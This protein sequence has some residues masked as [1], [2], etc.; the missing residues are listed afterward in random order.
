VQT[1]FV[2]DGAAITKLRC[3]SGVE[4]GEANSR[5]VLLLLI[6]VVLVLVLLMD[7]GLMLLGL[8]FRRGSRLGG[9]TLDVWTSLFQSEIIRFTADQPPTKHSEKNTN[10]ETP[11]LNQTHLLSIPSCQQQ[12]H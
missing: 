2:L 11:C 6:V 8:L 12:R 5:R 7:L 4:H 3:H 9:Q 1:V 10:H